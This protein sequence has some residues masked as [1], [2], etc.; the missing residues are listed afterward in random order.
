MASRTEASRSGSCATMFIGGILLDLG[1]V[2][3]AAFGGRLFSC[4]AIKY[5]HVDF[6]ERAG[7]GFWGGVGAL[8]VGNASAIHRAP[9]R[10]L[11]LLAALPPCE[12]AP[13][14]HAPNLLEVGR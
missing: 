11:E 6:G 12:P 2:V 13:Q 3:G 8:R 1:S 4:M 5:E 10:R 9:V 7:L 14:T